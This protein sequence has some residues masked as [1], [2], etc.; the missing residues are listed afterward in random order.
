M[1]R[2]SSTDI[3]SDGFVLMSA[4]IE[5]VASW[6]GVDVRTI[7]RCR[8]A[9]NEIVDQDGGKNST[10][11][12]SFSLSHVMPENAISWFR[13]LVEESH[14]TEQMPPRHLVNAAPAFGVTRPGIWHA[15]EPNAAPAFQ[16][17]SSI[18]LNKATASLAMLAEKLKSLGIAVGGGTDDWSRISVESSA[19]TRAECVD[20][21]ADVIASNE[22]ER[23]RVF[24]TAVVAQGKNFPWNFFR[25]AIVNGWW[26]TTR[27]TK[28]QLRT[29]ETMLRLVNGT[30]AA[31][32][33]TSTAHEAW[34]T[35]LAAMRRWD[36]MHQ[37]S[38]LR[39]ELG[40]RI[41]AAARQAGGFSKI[42]N[43]NPQFQNEIRRAFV[44]A[45]EANA[46]IASAM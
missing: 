15:E 38:Q 19:L 26:L 13:N 31:E 43:S 37:N 27:E 6:S 10:S 14:L 28:Q 17:L 7:Q 5:K 40:E 11:L 3:D 12:W 18:C 21:I 8:K 44:E 4:S 16:N 29:A 2:G 33:V 42:A 9:L 20:A 35:M 39:A 25:D 34:G 22:S 41:C 23:L 24:V 36:F 30:D 32:I 46:T 1:N 45:Y